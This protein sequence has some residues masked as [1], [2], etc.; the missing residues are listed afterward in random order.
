VAGVD[1][2]VVAGAWALGS[3]AVSLVVGAVVA[4][5]ERPAEPRRRDPHPALA[6][7]G[8]RASVL[9]LALPSPRTS[10]EQVAPT[11]L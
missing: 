9:P 4:R 6:A 10:V 7:P 3:V 2:L 5:A 8:S 1:V 11:A